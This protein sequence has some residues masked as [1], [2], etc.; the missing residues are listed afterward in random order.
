MGLSPSQEAN[1]KRT[2]PSDGVR[3]GDCVEAMRILALMTAEPR[4][5]VWADRMGSDLSDWVESLASKG[6]TPRNVECRL[7]WC[8][9][10]VG[11]AEGDL[12]EM[13]PQKGQ[14]MK[15]FDRLVLYA[16]DVDDP[17]ITDV[18]QFFKRYCKSLKE[19]FDGDSHLVP[20]FDTL[21]Q[22]C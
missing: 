10:E 15:I 13:S 2:A 18:L 1:C 8:I 3:H 12:F 20:N 9:V 4:D 21:G 6:I 14:K 17:K 19:V 11:S 5:K 22:K 16:P 7:S